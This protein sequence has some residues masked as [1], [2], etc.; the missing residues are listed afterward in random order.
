MPNLTTVG[1]LFVLI[2]MALYFFTN[3]IS[4]WT[5]VG[6]FRLIGGKLD[7]PSVLQFYGVAGIILMIVG[8]IIGLI[9]LL[10]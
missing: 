3:T 1:F 5:V 4:H 8:S 2:G 9:G 6:Y 10:P 7:Y